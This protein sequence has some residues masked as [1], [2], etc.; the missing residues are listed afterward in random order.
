MHHVEECKKEL[1]TVEYCDLSDK[2]KK[3]CLFFSLMKLVRLYQISR[4]EISASNYYNYKTRCFVGNIT[5]SD[6]LSGFM[7]CPYV[8]TNELNY[9][10][11]RNLN[12]DICRP[13]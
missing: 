2:K 1:W 13:R 9:E 6:K 7:K 3:N 11:R 10:F 4:Q 8:E 12:A 5:A